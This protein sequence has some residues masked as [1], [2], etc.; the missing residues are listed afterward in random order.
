[1]PRYSKKTY[2]LEK[3]NKDCKLIDAVESPSDIDFRSPERHIEDKKDILKNVLNYKGLRIGSNK[4]EI[5]FL[6]LG[7]CNPGRITLTL[8][9]EY[10]SALKRVRKFGNPTERKDNEKGLVKKIRPMKQLSLFR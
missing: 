9:G 6:P 2:T 3:Y 4:S 1:M 5:S 10:E 7:V 8:K